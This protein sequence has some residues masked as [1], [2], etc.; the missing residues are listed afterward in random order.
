MKIDRTSRMTPDEAR[1]QAKE[2]LAR[3]R[4][5]DDPA[6]D[7]AAARETPTV[8]AFAEQFLVSRRVRHTPKN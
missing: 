1:A 2:I 7:R 8:G 6:G 4:L 3:V 5:G